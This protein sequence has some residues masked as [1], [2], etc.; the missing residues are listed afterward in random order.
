M[1]Q[2]DNITPA[3]RMDPHRRRYPWWLALVAL[4]L[5]AYGITDAITHWG[6]RAEFKITHSCGI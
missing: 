1:I 2:D 6:E 5:L 4:L 3:E